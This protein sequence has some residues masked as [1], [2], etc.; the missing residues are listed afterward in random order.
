LY[1]SSDEELTNPLYEAT[2]N[3]GKGVFYT[4]NHKTIRFWGKYSSGK[5]NTYTKL[6]DGV[7]SPLGSS[8]ILVSE[9]TQVSTL[10]GRDWLKR[11]DH[12][13]RRWVRE[14]YQYQA[15]DVDV[16]N[17]Q[18]QFWQD[19]DQAWD[20][21]R[22]FRFRTSSYPLRYSDLYQAQV[23]NGAQIGTLAYYDSLYVDDTWHRI[24][25]CE[26]N[27]FSS[28]KQREIQLPMSWSDNEVTFRLNVNSL[29]QSDGLY[30]YL[31][32]SYGKASAAGTLLC[33]KCPV[34][35]ALSFSQ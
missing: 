18:L 32:D 23:S 6:G 5:N 20:V 26:S 22:R 3:E 7:D 4:F 28:C 34:G 11:I 30:V 15:G 21:S 14:E 29:S 9:Y 12:A 31:I 13:T 24:I 25:V 1:A 27:V 19:G 16:E 35:T 10:W 8:S 2:L 17:G 33:G